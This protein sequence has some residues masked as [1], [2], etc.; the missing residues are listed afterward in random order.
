MQFIFVRKVELGPNGQ[1]KAN[2]SLVG[3]TKE[4]MISIE[5]CVREIITLKDPEETNIDI[6]VPKEKEKIVKEMSLLEVDG[7]FPIYDKDGKITSIL[8]KVSDKY[9][10][11]TFF[12][13]WG[14][15]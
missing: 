2:V 11:V 9:D 5:E 6:L 13:E 3:D 7:E 15:A 4:S 8:I 1:P 10:F 14:S 12:K